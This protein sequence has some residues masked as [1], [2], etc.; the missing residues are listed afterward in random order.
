MGPPPA[1]AVVKEGGSP[2]EESNIGISGLIGAS[3]N[4]DIEKAMCWVKIEQLEEEGLPAQ[5]CP[6]PLGPHAAD[7]TRPSHGPTAT[8]PWRSQFSIK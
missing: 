3:T 1:A 2:L 6:R 5:P 4:R 8:A 7:A